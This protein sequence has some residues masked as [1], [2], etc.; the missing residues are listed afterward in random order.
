M[1]PISVVLFDLDDT[2]FA[3]RRAVEDGVIAH[4]RAI[5]LLEASV[6]TAAEARRWSELEEKHYTRY[7]HGELD[8]LGQRRAR[9][10][11]F[12]AP[13]G[14][15]F[16][17]DASAEEWFETY[18]H[19]YRA[20]WTLHDDA[21]TALGALGGYRLGII[22]NGVTHFQQPKLDAL[23][24]TGFFEHVVT[25]GDFGAVKPHPS[26][27]QHACSVFGVDPSEA[28]YVGD[29]LHTD[30]IGATQAGLTGIWLNRGPAP[31]LATRAEA[32]AAD[33][34]IIASL[35]ELPPRLRAAK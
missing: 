22:T 31:D 2:L 16:E 14:V 30:A 33:V 6:D 24:I 26:I 8:Y 7:L 21:L 9:A 1:T 32:D 13:Y 15:I 18:L 10:T 23:G 12:V 29:R 4:L 11:D 28:A 5:G 3:H 17:T 34:Q 35:A 25:S 20:A 27:F 19:E